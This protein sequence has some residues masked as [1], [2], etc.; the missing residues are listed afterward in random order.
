MYD[1]PFRKGYKPQFT[2]E[3]LEIV[4][5]LSRKPPTWTMNDG[6][7]EIIGGKFYQKEWIRVI[8]QWICF[9]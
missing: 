7:D 3:V 8:E 9:Q 1:L 4:A 5:I 6:Q 2:Q